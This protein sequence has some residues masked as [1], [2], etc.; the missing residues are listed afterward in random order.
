MNVGPVEM[1]RELRAHNAL[2]EDPDSIP[3][4]PHDG[5]EAPV[6]TMCGASVGEGSHQRTYTHAGTSVIKHSVNTYYVFKM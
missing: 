5:V 3:K 1:A 6:S 4:H 2:V